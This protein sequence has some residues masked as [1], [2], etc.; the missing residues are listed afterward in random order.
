LNVRLTF[1]ALVAFC[2]LFAL[3]LCNRKA[4]ER[5]GFAGIAVAV[6]LFLFQLWRGY[7]CRQ[8]LVM[9][10]LLFAA[11]AFLAAKKV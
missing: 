1:M 2:T 10:G 7:F 4:A 11:G 5:F 8:C 6:F 9:E 3:S